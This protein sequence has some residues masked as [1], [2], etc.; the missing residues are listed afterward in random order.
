MIANGSLSIVLKAYLALSVGIV[1]HMPEQLI[2]TC[3]WL[4]CLHNCILL[5]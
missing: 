2:N 3:N 4:L 5:H 1:V